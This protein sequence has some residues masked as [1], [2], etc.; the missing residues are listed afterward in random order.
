MTAAA[1]LL[2]LA[3]APPQLATADT[4]RRGGGAREPGARAAEPAPT[5]R[6]VNAPARVHARRLTTPIRVDG[7][8]DDAAWA[9]ADS[10]TA[11]VQREPDERAA[12]TQATIAWVLYDDAALYVAARLDDTAPDSVRA[13]LARRDRWMPADRFTVML[14]PYQD[15]RTGVFFGLNAAGT[16]YD[17]TLLNDDW[18]DDTWDGVWVGK[19][20]RTPT[21]WSVEMRIPLSQLRFNPGDAQVWGINFRR[22]I[23]RRNERDFLT[24]TPTNGAGF[25]S[26][27]IPMDGIT[28]LSPKP[29]REL[30][31]Y[32][33]N[34]AQSLVADPGDPF[35]GGTRMLPN[36]GL[37]AKL[38]LG[39]NL[40]L[41]A[42]VN[43]DFGQVEVDP[44]V[45]NLTDVEVFF[46]E[47]RPF[48]LEGQSIF[49]FG[50][51]GSNNF[52]GF[53]WF[54][55]DFLYTRRIGRSPRGS[56]SGARWI[57]RPQGTQLLGAAKLS[58]RIGDWTLGVMNATTNRES[59]RLSDGDR[60][61]AQEVEPLANYSTVRVNREWKKGF[62]G[63]GVLGTSVLRDFADPRL[64]DQMNGSAQGAGLDGW[65]FLDANRVWV[66]SGWVG[67]SRITGTRQQ[68]IAQ[69]RNSV[70]YFQRPDAPHLRVDSM[71]T[72]LDGVAGRITLNKQRGNW[73]VNSAFGLI[74]PGFDVNDLGF[75][76]RADHINW[77]GVVGYRWTQPTSWYQ[78]VNLNV[79]LAQSWDFG[80]NHVNNFLWTN[81]WIRFK[82]FNSLNWNVSRSFEVT[83]VRLTRGGPAMLR[84]SD[85]RGSVWYNSDDRKSFTYGVG[86]FAT[87]MA[88][89]ADRSWGVD[90]ATEWRPSS[91]L[92]LRVSP[93]FSRT[94][95]GR[96]YLQAVRDPLATAT[97]GARYLFGDLEQ[98]S[99]SANIRAN[100]IFT[101]RLSFE[102]FVQPL[103]SSGRYMAVKELRTPRT[104]SFLTYGTAGS[105]IDR[106]AGT[107]DP[108]GAGPA[109]AI[110]IGQPDFTFVSLRGNAVIRWEY[111]P[112]STLFLVWTQN[113]NASLAN[114]DFD[115]GRAVGD[116]R[117]AP[118]D[119]V[120][121]VKV[122]YWLN[123]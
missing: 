43:P 111:V 107:A 89:G 108:D 16:Q 76:A 100:W 32:V 98:T 90:L 25:V 78:R 102:L 99:L 118:S 27:F 110:R 51:G 116:L 4:A 105:T 73:A 74:S 55:V 119:N 39:N 30:L 97:F 52:W 69:Q 31:P 54:G 36:V 37:D 114:G 87:R 80:G 122:T 106:A 5:D 91:S 53:N 40:T 60:T 85:V 79:A 67:G 41:D 63:L 34:R 17:G 35:R 113:R 3:T 109:P 49:Q 121:A 11:F 117:Q 46:E 15:R 57:D 65:T 61:W 23:A 10:V 123:P 64:M 19:V 68:M 13:L 84:P 115:L 6:A 81:G 62:R 21:G 1:L 29:R 24:F 59:A 2:L 83:D 38:G 8:L 44:A 96:Q 93:S 58:G 42:S 12:P 33:T 94:L 9:Q 112:G 66:L 20:A 95:T 77:H 92:T 71:A 103:V 48:F 26:R 18:D 120:F 75:Q 104:F 14:D 50:A 70:H 45:V 101:P 7:R 28:G 47:R 56:A 72:S 22:D 88:E 86:M 82:G